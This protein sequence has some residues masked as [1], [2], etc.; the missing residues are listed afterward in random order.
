MRGGV[1]PRPGNFRI[2]HQQ[3]REALA[4]SDAAAVAS[5]T[6]TL[7]AALLT[8]PMVIVYKE[9]PVN[10][11]TLGRLITAEHFGLVNL[12]AGKRVVTELMQHDLSGKRLAEELLS[13]LEPGR[14]AEMRAQ[15]REVTSNLGEGGAS[16]RA[17]ES[18]LRFLK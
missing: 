10:W 1:M 6:A 18:I 15:L 16:Q 3:T 13:L 8:T 9:S 2:T 14:N 7:E 17:A 12:I 5:G 4:A 11:H